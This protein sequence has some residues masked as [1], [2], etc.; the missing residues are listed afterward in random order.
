MADTCKQCGLDVPPNSKLKNFCSYAHRG[1][2]RASEAMAGPS[3]LR[4]SKNTKQNK[5]LQ[6]LKRQ[7]L[8]QLTF[9]KIN[10]ITYRVDGPGKKAVGWLMEIA[11]PYSTMQRWVARI[12]T[13]GSQP[14]TLQGGKLAASE[15]L[16]DRTKGVSRTSQEWVGELNQL[17]AGGI[18]RAVIVRERKR[19]PTD[20]LGG[21]GHG[22]IDSKTRAL[23]IDTEIDVR[24]KLEREAA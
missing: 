5:A 21:P 19:W 24:L 16:R 12:D 6:T 7:S 22:A 2:F 15:M 18:D 3:G 10:S 17:A 4:G 1:V 20:I 13:R 9:H 23:V 11:W 14:L 8:G